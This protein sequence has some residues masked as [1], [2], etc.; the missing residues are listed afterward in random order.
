MEEQYT[1]DRKHLRGRRALF[2]QRRRF[3]DKRP[4]GLEHG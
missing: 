1:K 2:E 4:S 3:F